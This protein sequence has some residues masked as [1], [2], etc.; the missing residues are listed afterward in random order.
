VLLHFDDDIH[1]FA[2]RGLLGHDPDGVVERR[3]G[4]FELDV[5]HGTNHL[6]DLADVLRVHKLVSLLGWA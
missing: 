4:A 1:R 3:E 6:N 5:H 2:G